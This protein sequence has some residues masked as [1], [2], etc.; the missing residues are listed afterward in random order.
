MQQTNLRR[1]DSHRREEKSALTEELIL[2][3]FD[4]DTQRRWFL[5]IRIL[6]RH[7]RS[8]ETVSIEGSRCF[9]AYEVLA[10]INRLCAL[11][12]PHRPIYLFCE[13]QRFTQNILIPIIRKK[14][15]G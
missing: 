8:A 13:P 12:S 9:R 6:A 1:F 15:E 11:L 7:I 4:F 3:G 14:I 2:S 5:A 10:V